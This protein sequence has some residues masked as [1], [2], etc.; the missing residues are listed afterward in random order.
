[1]KISY[2]FYPPKD[3]NFK[4]VV[5]EYAR[6]S[7]FGPRF[8]SITYGALGSSQKNS[9]GLIKAF[10]ESHNIDIV[11]HLTLVGKTKN[12]LDLI[13]DEF[14]ELGVTK[15]VA[16]RGDVAEGNFL[17]H[18]EGFENT[19]EF[20]ESLINNGM[21]VIVSAYPEPHPESS[22]F[23]FDLNLLKSKTLAG[24][25]QSISQFCFSSHDYQRL[26]TAIKHHNINS[27]L[28][29]G[30]MPIYNITSLCNMAKRCGTNIPS[31]IINQFSDDVQKNEEASI[32][33]CIKQIEDLQSMGINSFHF[34]ALNQSE[35]LQKILSQVNLS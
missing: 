17:A 19:S 5:E 1:M 11:A 33:I 4:K 18:K 26:I 2:E 13:I 16:L 34:Y 31:E 20:V 7:I 14:K 22:G 24:A 28:I 9:I 30:I 32:K 21:E 27:E 6:L 12:Q 29:A 8:I 10:K 25:K 35:L 23:N 15:I 3:M